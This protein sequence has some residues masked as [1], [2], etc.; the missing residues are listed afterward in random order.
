ML[1][2]KCNIWHVC[3]RRNDNRICYQIFNLTSIIF[4]THNPEGHKMRVTYQKSLLFI[5]LVLAV[6][7][8]YAALKNHTTIYDNFDSLVI[9]SLPNIK[10]PSFTLTSKSDPNG[11]CKQYDTCG[12][13]VRV[14]DMT[15]GLIPSGCN[16]CLYTLL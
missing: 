10:V 12:S 9:S 14:I 11:D 5:A 8:D 15:G 1:F 2:P 4:H 13:D 7:A 6:A 16:C 3:N